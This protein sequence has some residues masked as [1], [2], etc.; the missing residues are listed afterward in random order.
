MNGWHLYED[1]QTCGWVLRNG[2]HMWLIRDDLAKKPLE[3]VVA[4]VLSWRML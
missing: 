1:L 4:E 2:N 3:E